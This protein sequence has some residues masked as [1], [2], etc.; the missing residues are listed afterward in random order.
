L[1]FELAVKR[2]RDIDRGANGILLHDG[3]IPCVP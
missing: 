1:R 2:C 3:I